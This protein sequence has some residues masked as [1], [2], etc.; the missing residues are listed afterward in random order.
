MEKF[1]K[2]FG[3]PIASW[4]QKVPIDSKDNNA[5]PTPR[6][7]PTGRASVAPTTDT[8]L[9]YSDSDK[10]V[11]TPEFYLELIPYIRKIVHTNPNMSQALSNIV[12]LGNT[13]HV[14]NFDPSVDPKKIVEMRQHLDNVRKKWAPAK[15]SADGITDK[16]MRQI[17]ISGALSVEWVPK[18]DLSGIQMVAMV[19]PETVRWQYDKRKNQYQP[20]QK[21][22]NSGTKNFPENNL[23]KL[24]P[25]TFNYFA[26][27]GDTDIP[28]GIPPYLASLDPYATQKIMKDNLKFLMEQVG[29]AGFMEMLMEKPDIQGGESHDQYAS[30]LSKFLD[31]AKA[32]A[33]EGFRDGIS[34][35]YKED[36]EFKFHA[37]SKSLQGVSEFYN[38]NEMDFSSGLNMDSSMLGRSYGTSESQITVVFTKLLS[39]LNTIQQMVSRCWEYG[40]ALEL[41]LAGFEFKTLTVEFN[42]STALD[43]L[44]YQQAEELRIR[45]ANQLYVDGIISQ[46]QYAHRVGYES[47]NMAEPRFLPTSLETP[48]ERAA[49]QKAENAKK[50]ETDKKGR[51]KK[52]PQD[53]PKQNK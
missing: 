49:R 53:I 24:N 6:V 7:L 13:G 25:H 3:L 52:K 38:I 16:M 40:Y 11:L 29:L 30:R 34:V 18:N 12:E 26:L 17:M 9:P 10:E 19:N 41:R 32:R 5:M 39:Q 28:Y 47:P 42:P 4:G 43:E 20:M 45:N 14:I 8:I 22:D 2:L 1:I 21:V 31:E 46:E 35:G 15:A 23:V 33:K 36:T 51:Q 37:T 48:Q 44:K 27:N 50:N